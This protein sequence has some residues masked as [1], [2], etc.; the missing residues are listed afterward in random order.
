MKPSIAPF[1]ARSRARSRPSLTRSTERVCGRA[2]VLPIGIVVS[3]TK[4]SLQSPATGRMT[5]AVLRRKHAAPHL[6]E[7]L[8]VGRKSTPYIPYRGKN[9]VIPYGT[10][11]NTP[12]RTAPA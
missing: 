11:A 8:L 6:L 3:S 9:T 7:I 4:S 1:D 10:A 12:H 5:P 2:F